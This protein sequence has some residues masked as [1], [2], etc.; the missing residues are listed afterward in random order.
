MQFILND[1]YFV[2]ELESLYNFG[3]NDFPRCAYTSQMEA[4]EVCGEEKK[5]VITFK[6]LLE[7]IKVVSERIK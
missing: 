6:E 4:M 2:I 1:L 7:I 3:V 5:T